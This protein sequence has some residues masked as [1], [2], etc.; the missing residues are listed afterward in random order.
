[1]LLS[2]KA[3]ATCCG[4]RAAEALSKSPRF[5]MACKVNESSARNEFVWVDRF[6]DSPH[7]V[8]FLP[9]RISAAQ[10]E[11]HRHNAVIPVFDDRLQR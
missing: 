1:M 5:F 7:R 11:Q 8:A 10:Y 4:L 6:I 3:M 2:S 9:G